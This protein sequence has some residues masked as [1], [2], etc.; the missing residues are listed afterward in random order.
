MIK[1]NKELSLRFFSKIIKEGHMRAAN[2]DKIDVKRDHKNLITLYYYIE[3]KS[4][5]QR[6]LYK[7]SASNKIN[8]N[9]R[10]ER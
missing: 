3:F 1:S 6:L 7:Q 5:V 9:N 2:I 4:I 10:Y 8:E